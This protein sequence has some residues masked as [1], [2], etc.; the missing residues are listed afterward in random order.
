MKR[1]TF[2]KAAA[3][4]SVALT[5][6][7]TGCSRNG[8]VNQAA[9]GKIM[10]V[11]GPIDPDEL[12]VALPHEHVMSMFG[13][14]P[15]EKAVYDEGAL[16]AAVVPYLKSVKALGA[17]ALMD[18][19]TAYFGRAPELLRRISEQSGMTLLT[20]TGYYGAA[21]DRYV[22]QHAYNESAEQLAERWA[23][24]MHEGIDGTDIRPGFIKIG[25]DDDGLSEI[26]AKLI[27]AAA[28]AHLKTGLVVEIHTGENIFAAEKQF[29]IFKEEG[30]HPSAWIWVH[31]NKNEA[32]PLIKAAKM[33][34]WIELDGVSEGNN[35][36]HLALL[37]EFKINDL[38][39]CVL[40][41]HDGNS[42]RATGR[43]PKPY[44]DLFKTFIPML[45]ENGWSENEIKLLTVDNPKSAFTIRVRALG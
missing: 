33:G 32:G 27:R 22:P 3:F 34:A 35:E 42:F 28:K 2:L 19:T 13:A 14:A 39:D 41:S 36:A 5:A 15:A 8:L 9:E 44:D 37:N 38:L 4:S 6:A 20:N 30:V 43:P 11:L 45:R 31:A 10:T 17:D 16:F 23:A 25:V 29:D 12:G 21:N 24:E 26:D 40:L 18:C 7:S 1:R